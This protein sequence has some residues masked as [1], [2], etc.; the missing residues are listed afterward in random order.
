MKAIALLISL[1]SAAPTTTFDKGP[2]FEVTY[3]SAKKML[4][5]AVDVPTNMY[6]A[7]SYGTA[8]TAV[9]MVTFQGEGDGIVTDYWLGATG[10][11]V[12]DTQQDYKNTLVTS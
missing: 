8:A 2:S 4:K 11:A 6:L 12:K 10:P 7:L 3:D 9:D 5:Y 1:I